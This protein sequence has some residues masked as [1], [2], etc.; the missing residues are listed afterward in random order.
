MVAWAGEGRLAD[1]SSDCPLLDRTH[2]DPAEAE[3]E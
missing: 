2:D 1:T 3:D